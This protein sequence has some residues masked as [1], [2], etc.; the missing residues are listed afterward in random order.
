MEQPNPYKPPQ[1]AGY[2]APRTPATYSK[3]TLVLA[4]GAVAW[5]ALMALVVATALVKTHFPGIPKSTLAALTV[6]AVAFVVIP[7]YAVFKWIRLRG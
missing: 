1:D 3:A 4:T 5:A 6:V 7:T 2:H